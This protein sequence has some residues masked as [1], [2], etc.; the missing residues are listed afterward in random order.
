MLVVSR[1]LRRWPTLATDVSP[2][3]PLHVLVAAW[4]LK[5]LK[6]TEEAVTRPHVCGAF[7]FGGDTHCHVCQ[8]TAWNGLGQGLGGPGLLSFDIF[9]QGKKPLD[10]HAGG[11]GKGSKEGILHG[12]SG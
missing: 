9:S 8:V 6:S 2:P 4:D 12:G 1:R 7:V 5:A 3:P 10:L 11:L